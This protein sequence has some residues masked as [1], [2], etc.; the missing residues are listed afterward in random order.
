MRRDTK[1]SIDSWGELEKNEKWE[2]VLFGTFVRFY[3]YR[4]SFI[5]NQMFREPISDNNCVIF[6]IRVLREIF[7]VSFLP[8]SV[9]RLKSKDS[10][11][12]ATWNLDLPIVSSILK[13]SQ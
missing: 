11:R 1:G 5:R 2:F 10:I 4:D 13:L 6:R 9:L 12:P 8:F 7:R 3:Y